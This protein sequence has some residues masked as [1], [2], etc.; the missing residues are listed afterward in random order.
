MTEKR[1]ADGDRTRE[2]PAGV[3]DGPTTRARLE[4]SLDELLRSAHENGVRVEG[5]YEVDGGDSDEPR[6]GVEI[7][8]VDRDV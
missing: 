3:A 4:R 8:R 6:W 7:Y 1:S 5:G 2:H